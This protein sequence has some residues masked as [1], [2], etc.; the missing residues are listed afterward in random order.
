MSP[1]ERSSP[2][3]HHCA[4]ETRISGDDGGEGQQQ[5]PVGF[6]RET[7]FN[8]LRLATV[9]VQHLRDK[10]EASTVCVA[11]SYPQSHERPLSDWHPQR[12]T[13]DS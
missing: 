2:E 6:W 7:M 1:Q 9:L 5:Y 8:D 11:K 12:G 3:I 10:V 4:G 13:L